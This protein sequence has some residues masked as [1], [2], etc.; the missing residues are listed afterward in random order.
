MST[1]AQLA[2]SRP[3]KVNKLVFKRAIVRIQYEMEDVKVDELVHF[4]ELPGRCEPER[5]IRALED[6]RKHYKETAARVNALFSDAIKA[7]EKTRDGK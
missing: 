2:N 1:A 5:I 6:D 4:T 3:D 7:V